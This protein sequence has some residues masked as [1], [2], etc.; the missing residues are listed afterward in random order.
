MTDRLFQ[1]LE[2]AGDNVRTIRR[3]R[4]RTS[5]SSGTKKKPQLKSLETEIGALLSTLNF[6]FFFLPAPWSADALDPAEIEVLAKQI[7]LVALD[8]PAVYRYL[9]WA[10]KSGGSTMNLI[11]LGA[12][13]TGRRLSR[14]GYIP[15]EWD[16][17]LAMMLGNMGASQRSVS[18][19]MNATDV[20]DNDTSSPNEPG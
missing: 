1:N 17:N 19:S 14:H 8:N 15:P 10:F 20:N 5:Q 9:E 16:N 4:V 6:A 18:E 7:N 13:I 2:A 3:T 11:L 12:I